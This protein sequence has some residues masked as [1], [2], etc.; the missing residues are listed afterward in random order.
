M[1]FK[2]MCGNVA[3]TMQRIG[4]AWF[5]VVVAAVMAGSVNNV[6]GAVRE[7][8]SC[9]LATNGANAINN[10]ASCDLATGKAISNINSGVVEGKLGILGN[11][12]I[13]WG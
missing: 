2:E 13:A 3:R 4:P 9:D 10:L 7:V 8:A 6:A 11:V 5:A 12:R 1:G